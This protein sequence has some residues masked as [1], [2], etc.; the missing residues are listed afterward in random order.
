MTRNLPKN[1]GMA[2][3]KR[4]RQTER[5]PDFGGSDSETHPDPLHYSKCGKG[6]GGCGLSTDMPKVR[7]QNTGIDG[8]WHMSIYIY[9]YMYILYNMS[10]H[11]GVHSTL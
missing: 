7:R 10:S 5:N 8:G 9:V 3:A 1:A 6:I 11:T 2:D 4:Q